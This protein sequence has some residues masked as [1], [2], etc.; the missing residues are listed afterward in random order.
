MQITAKQWMALVLDNTQI[1]IRNVK[2]Q[3]HH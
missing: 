2:G 1:E 3:R